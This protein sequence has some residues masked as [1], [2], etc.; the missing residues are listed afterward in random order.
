GTKKTKGDPVVDNFNTLPFAERW[1]AKIMPEYKDYLRRGLF[2]KQ[3]SHFAVLREHKG[4]MISQAE[5]TI[6]FDG[7]T[8]TVT[9]A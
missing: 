4:A 2:M 6:L 5:H 1:L 8:V 3:I 9:T 7:D